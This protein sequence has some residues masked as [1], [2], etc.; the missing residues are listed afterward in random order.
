MLTNQ[1]IS[2]KLREHA[3]ALAHTGGNLYRIRAFRNAALAV[4]A[5]PDEVSAIL[6]SAGPHALEQLPGI[7]KSLAA[8]IAEYAS[9]GGNQDQFRPDVS[10]TS[11]HRGNGAVPTLTRSP[12]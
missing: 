11:A 5:L 7:G 12:D 10:L 1:D 8:T 6:T 4:L 2:R 9:S 3:A